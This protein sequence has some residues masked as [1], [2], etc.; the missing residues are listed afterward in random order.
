MT[1]ILTGHGCFGE[2]LHRIGKEGTTSCHH[3][4]DGRNTA[5][6]TLDSCSAW[7]NERRALI[8]VIGFDLFPRAVVAAMLEEEIK[9]RAVVSFCETVMSRK[10][11]AEKEKERE[12]HVVRQPRRHH[13]LPAGQSAIYRVAGGEAMPPPP[14]SPPPPR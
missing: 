7:V 14:L 4:E 10:E 9:W 11:A 3:C 1:Q 12:R 6:H 13:R 8:D 5:Q 2:Y